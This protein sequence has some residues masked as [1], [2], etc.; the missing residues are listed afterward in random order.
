[1]TPLIGLFN[2][3]TNLFYFSKCSIGSFKNKLLTFDYQL[4]KIFYSNRKLRSF[5]FLRNVN[6]KVACLLNS[7]TTAITSPYKFP[8]QSY[9]VN[10]QCQLVYGINSTSVGCNVGQRI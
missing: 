7:S 8:G 6:P 1:M 4:V 3:F 9:S 2:N 10:Q 5:I